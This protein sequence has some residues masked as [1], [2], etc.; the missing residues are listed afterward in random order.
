LRETETGEE[1]E[2]EI[3]EDNI[4]IGRGAIAVHILCAAMIFIY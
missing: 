3:V 2:K 1:R 4:I